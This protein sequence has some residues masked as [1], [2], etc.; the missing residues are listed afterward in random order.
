MADHV[1]TPTA[2][3]FLAVD[4]KLLIGGERVVPARSDPIAVFNH[5]SDKQI[6]EVAG[7]GADR[8]F[9][10]PTVYGNADPTMKIVSEEI[11][12]PVL[13]MQS[14]AA[15]D[16][17]ELAALENTTQYGLAAS[18]WTKNVGSGGREDVREGVEAYTEFKSVAIV[19]ERPGDWLSLKG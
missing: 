16:L 3:A 10:A 7:G 12:G 19:N 11:F 6:A 18:L 5:A 2:A 15:T 13:A 9:I 1:P 14:F 4:H 17:D 8:Y